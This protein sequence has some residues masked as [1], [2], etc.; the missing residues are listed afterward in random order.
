MMKFYTTLLLCLPYSNYSIF[1]D[2]L[3]A[4]LQLLKQSDQNALKTKLKGGH[5][6]V[7]STHKTVLTPN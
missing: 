4:L 6:F 5:L 7:S 2:I 1:M 3:V